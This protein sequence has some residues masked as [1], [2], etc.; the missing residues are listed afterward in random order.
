VNAGLTS[1]QT[2]LRIREIKQADVEPIIDL[3]AR[4]FPK[5]RRYWEV[6]LDRLRMR[7]VPPG[8]PR[9]GYMLEADGRPVGTILLISSLRRSGGRK[10]LF[11]NLS[12]WHV[13]PAFR[14]HATL[15]FRRA[16]ANKQA[17]Y[18][19]VSASS[20]VLPIIEAFGFKRYSEGQ[21]LG[22]PALTRNR[23]RGRACVIDA[24]RFAECDLEEDERQLLTAQVGYGCI[25]FCCKAS[26]STYPFVFI[27]RL[28][29]GVIPCAQLAYC[30]KIADVADVAGTVGRHLV[31]LGWPF[32]LI[33]A[34]GPV[35]GIPGKYFPSATPK[36]Y[37]GAEPP[38]PGDLL[39][40]EATILGF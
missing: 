2:G 5:P 28:I 29:R 24:N 15:L 11:T 32:V 25:V 37:R 14:S 33:D 10:V 13:E 34:S 23:Q 39:E 3:L 19:S 27:P 20:H 1:R 35:P 38:V 22:F 21:M 16:L 6:G 30:R 17:T 36:Y 8:T 4:G 12:S 9:Y 7:S 40:T 18:L 26:G 31:R